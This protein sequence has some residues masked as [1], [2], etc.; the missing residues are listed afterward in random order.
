[1]SASIVGT[2]TPLRRV[3][4][5][6]AEQVGG[7]T[8]VL[9]PVADRYCRLNATGG[10]LFALLEDG[11]R[12]PDQL[13]RALAADRGIDPERALRDVIVFAED[14]AARGLLEVI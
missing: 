8:V 7:A 6:L 2:G 9:D 12:T 3:P 11:P 4:H 13:A 14:L 5:A 1:M 10:F